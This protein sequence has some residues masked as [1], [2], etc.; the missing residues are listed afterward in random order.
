MSFVGLRFDVDADDGDRWSDALLD[1][2]ASSVDA[3][4]PAA[5]TRAERAVFGEPS[6]A[7][8]AWWPVT[9]LTALCTTGA[10]AS[11]IVRSAANALGCP[12]PVFETYA[13]ADQDWVRAT[14][15]QFGPI[16]ITNALWI[17]PTWCEPPHRDALNIVLDPGLA[18]GTGTHPTTRLCL[19]WL[20]ENVTPGVSVAR[21]RLRFGH[22]RDCRGQ[23]RRT[24]CRGRR[25][26]HAGD[27]REPR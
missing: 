6:D 27:T 10:D 4:D 17:V 7:A 20:T 19:R 9:R 2:G 11:A 8:P 15:A 12:M 26:R 14:Q 25:H 23:A 21:S 16:G 22:S 13:V 5:G 18:F 24:R 1:A 3:A